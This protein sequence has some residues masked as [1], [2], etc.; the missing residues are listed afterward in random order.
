MPH[1]SRFSRSGLPDRLDMG[2]FVKGCNPFAIRLLVLHCLRCTFMPSVVL[3][4]VEL[5][6]SCGFESYLRSHSF[7]QFTDGFPFD[8]P[9]KF[10][11]TPRRFSPLLLIAQREGRFGASTDRLTRSKKAPFNT[12]RDA[13]DE[14]YK[15]GC[16][17][18]TP[19]ST[20]EREDLCLDI[21]PTVCT[22][23]P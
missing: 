18:K 19:P 2:R 20:G 8:C 1:F 3:H 22:S 12:D 21:R 6:L 11:K 23:V 14:L 7:Y 17:E 9:A 13:V 15:K 5:T 10:S 16:Q 4:V